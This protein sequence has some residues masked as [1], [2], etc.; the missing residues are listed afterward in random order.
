MKFNFINEVEKNKE[1][2]KIKTDKEFREEGK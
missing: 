1:S 2:E